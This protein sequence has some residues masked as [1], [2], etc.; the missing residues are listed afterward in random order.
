MEM[1]ATTARI[2]ELANAI[3][4]E[5]GL[6]FFDRLG[7]GKGNDSTTSF[8]QELHTRV[9]AELGAGL[10]EICL[11]GT[12]K[13]CVDFYIRHERTIIEIELGARNPHTNF[14]RDIFKGLLAKDEGCE[15]DYLIIIGKPG[16]VKRLQ[17][18]D[19]RAIANW[20]QKHHSIGI[21]IYDLCA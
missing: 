10:G 20:V 6:I 12:N 7:P 21:Q 19:A 16:T 8:M 2:L 1:S 3:A 15:I 14:E 9:R 4:K 13:L 17:M 18:P 5:R 11:C